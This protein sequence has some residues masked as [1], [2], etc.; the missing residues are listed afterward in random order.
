MAI[1]R[2]GAALVGAVVLIFVI[3]SYVGSISPLNSPQANSTINAV[4]IAAAYAPEDDAPAGGGEVVE[5]DLF[6]MI[7]ASSAADGERAAKACVACHSFEAGGSNKTGPNLHNMVGQDKAIVDGFTY[8]DA[9]VAMD[10]VWTYENLDAFLTDP[11]GY[12][13]GTKMNYRGVRKAEDRAAIIA[14]MMSETDAP[15]P[16]EPT[17]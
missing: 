15:P 12:V 4:A 3:N 13:E 1:Y 10:G 2:F 17:E 14:Y 8:S 9:L 16:L 7:G 6:A 5:G 11:K